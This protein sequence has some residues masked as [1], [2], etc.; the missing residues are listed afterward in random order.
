MAQLL[1]EVSRHGQDSRRFYLRDGLTIGR[2]AQNDITLE[3]TKV[4]GS[5]A[6]IVMR[7]GQYF[8]TDVGSSN[9]THVFD[10]PSL[11]EGED[12]LIEEGVKF[13]VGDS[14]FE[15]FLVVIE[16]EATIQNPPEVH[17]EKAKPSAVDPAPAPDPEPGV[18]DAERRPTARPRGS[19]LELPRDGGQHIG[20]FLAPHEDLAPGETNRPTTAQQFPQIDTGILREALGDR[21]TE[22][23]RRPGQE[24]N[25]DKEPE[26]PG[27]GKTSA[28]F[29][30]ESTI[31]SGSRPPTSSEGKTSASRVPIMP[32][33]IM[34]D[35]ENTTNSLE[36]NNLLTSRVR[37]PADPDPDEATLLSPPPQLGLDGATARVSTNQGDMKPGEDTTDQVVVY[38]IPDDDGSTV[39]SPV[40][41]ANASAQTK[42]SE[43]GAAWPENSVGPDEATLLS[44]AAKQYSF[45]DPNDKTKAQSSI[46][47]SGQRLSMMRP[48]LVF[49]HDR[50]K[51]VV[52]IENDEFTLGRSSLKKIVNVNCPIDHSSI[53]ANHAAVLHRDGWF[54][55]EDRDSRNGTTVNGRELEPM[56]RAKLKLDMAIKVGAVDALFVVDRNQKLAEPDRGHYRL[57]LEYLVRQ[58]I[59]RQSSA[60]DLWM[61]FSRENQHPG[62]KLILEGRIQVSQWTEALNAAAVD[63]TLSGTS[64]ENWRVLALTTSAVAVFMLALFLL[65]RTGTISIL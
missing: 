2:E 48:R 57:A 46:I 7:N 10:G 37:R 26:P 53:S 47:G 38:K 1:F 44:P 58:K 8:V 28:A 14:E 9:R 64:R 31:P 49:S 16:N 18:D 59:I 65:I 21:P 29:E 36:I 5:H 63:S 30:I 23:A 45:V 22:L 52:Q 43:Q 39:L 33:S 20:A 41:A 42:K 17:E 12:W 54:F 24:L 4:S 51:F 62:E 56:T 61:A 50:F 11:G 6:K 55:L 13:K 25:E 19:P 3:D 35:S 40:I 32:P 15:A 60:K 27:E 34:R